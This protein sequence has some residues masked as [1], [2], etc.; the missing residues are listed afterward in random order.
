M[1]VANSRWYFNWANTTYSKVEFTV[2]FPLAMGTEPENN[3]NNIWFERACSSH[4]VTYRQRNFC[5]ILAT[6]LFLHSATFLM[7]IDFYLQQESLEF[8]FKKTATLRARYLLKLF[9]LFFFQINLK[10]DQKHHS[11]K[12]YQKIQKRILAWKSPVN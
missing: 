3:E 9:F 8:N 2:I 11:R 7:R 5:S 6:T 12:Y 1:N 4:S 10:S